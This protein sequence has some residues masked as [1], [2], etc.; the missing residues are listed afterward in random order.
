MLFSGAIFEITGANFAIFTPANTAC[1]PPLSAV[2]AFLRFSSLW[3]SRS[4]RRNLAR[5]AFSESSFW[6][7]SVN[8]VWS[9]SRLFEKLLRE[10]WCEMCCAVRILSTDPL[11]TGLMTSP[12]IDNELARGCVR[13]QLSSHHLHRTI[14]LPFLSAPFAFSKSICPD[15]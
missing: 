11:R 6:I 10:I 4:S 13:L 1:I 9:L 12:G 3:I 15:Y 2:W 7:C 8:F 5:I 14:S